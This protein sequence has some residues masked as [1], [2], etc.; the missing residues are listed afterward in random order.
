MPSII[1]GLL[2]NRQCRRRSAVG[3]LSAATFLLMARQTKDLLLLLASCWRPRTPRNLTMPVRAN[4][5]STWPRGPALLY[6]PT[7]PDSS[8]ASRTSRRFVDELDPGS[9]Q[10]G[11]DPRQ[12]LDHPA[13]SSVARFHSL[14]R[15]KGHSRR[16]RQSF[17]FHAHKCPSRLHLGCS[18][19]NPS[20]TQID[21]MSG[22]R[23]LPDGS[24]IIPDLQIMSQASRLRSSPARCRQAARVD[25]QRTITGYDETSPH[26][27]I[28]PYS[29]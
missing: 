17:L 12:T 27:K 13:D 8:A 5:R 21:D 9:L 18:E 11:H 15:R 7:Q 4:R 25:R 1:A 26:N 14:N 23:D 29:S 19:Q 3:Y 24:H 28:L 22:R 6:A 20:P 2:R 10:R 16:L